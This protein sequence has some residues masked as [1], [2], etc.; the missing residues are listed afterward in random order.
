M[1]TS[2]YKDFMKLLRVF[3]NA[4]QFYSMDIMTHFLNREQNEQ[5]LLLE[6]DYENESKV[7]F[8]VGK[9]SFMLICEDRDIKFDYADI[10]DYTIDNLRKDNMNIMISYNNEKIKFSLTPHISKND[11][12]EEIKSVY[13]QNADIIKR[14]DSLDENIMNLIKTINSLYSYII[15]NNHNTSN[16]PCVAY[17]IRIPQTYCHNDNKNTEFALNAHTTSL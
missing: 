11:T 5:Y 13:I 2:E 3:R 1:K 6:M 9:S 12:I 14:I 17:P 8:A 7:I 15:D 10:H 16:K 4:A